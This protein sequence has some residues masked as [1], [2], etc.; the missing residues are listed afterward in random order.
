MCNTC[1]ILCSAFFHGIGHHYCC[2]FMRILYYYDPDIY[3]HTL[4]TLHIIDHG[5]HMCDINVIIIV[6]FL[7]ITNDMYTSIYYL[8]CVRVTVNI[9]YYLHPRDRIYR[10]FI[11][12]LGNDWSSTMKVMVKIFSFIHNANIKISINNYLHCTTSSL[13]Y[14][15]KQIYKALIYYMYIIK[16]LYCAYPDEYRRTILRIVFM[17]AQ[18]CYNLIIICMLYIH[19]YCS[20]TYIITIAFFRNIFKFA[21][22]YGLHHDDKIIF[23]N[24][25]QKNRSICYNTA[26]NEMSDISVIYIQRELFFLSVLNSLHYICFLH[27]IYK[28]HVSYLVIFLKVCRLCH[29]LSYRLYYLRIVVLYI[30]HASKYHYGMSLFHMKYKCQNINL[31]RYSN[32]NPLTTNN[33][34]Y[35]SVC[36]SKCNNNIIHVWPVLNNNIPRLALNNTHHSHN[37]SHSTI[38]TTCTDDSIVGRIY[39][40]DQDYST[41]GNIDPDKY[42]LNSENNIP[43]KNYTEISFN[44]TFESKINTFSI[45]HVNI[46]STPENLS[47]LVYYL[48]GINL[49]F[50][51]FA[52]SESWLKSYNDSLYTIKGYAHECVNREDRPG[53]GVTLYIKKSIN[54]KLRSDLTL[55]VDDVNILFIEIPKN[56][57]NTQTNVLVGVCYRPPHVPA[58]NFIE[59]LDKLLEKIHKEKSIVFFC[60]D[61]NFDTLSLSPAINS[62]A[63]DFHNTFLSYFY[64]PLINNNVTRKNT[65]TGRGSLIDNVFTN[66]LHSSN[67]CQSAILKTD[68]S[69]HYSIIVI[70]DFTLCSSKE[71]KSIIKREFTNKNKSKLNKKLRLQSWDYLFNSENVQLAYTYFHNQIRYMYEECFP[72][73]RIQITYSY[74]LPWMTNNIRTSIKQKHNLY[75]IYVNNPTEENNIKYKTYK[76]KL[77][78]IMRKSERNYFEEQIEHNNH[79]LRKSWKTIKEIIGKNGSYDNTTISYNIN[80]VSTDDPQIFC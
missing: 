80:G 49:Q 7:S 46:R 43:C 44:S 52:I 16:I 5:R 19:V 79:D 75:A 48:Q 50:T 65:I 39:E 28:I 12:I 77:T 78:S 1:V 31:L 27:Y 33:Y 58:S 56:E 47:K 62:R 54:Y 64:K 67:T 66:L 29:I 68:F 3:C 42:F 37:D 74:R 30:F 70:S 38:N 41:L 36:P 17:F 13:S 71:N 25:R 6:S 4:L 21:Q 2:Y 9:N 55:S 23:S 26:H 69:D 22:E 15:L 34:R 10:A 73:S 63:N 76:N 24:N 72:E 60:G 14:T 57:L 8:F 11:L 18:Y 45:Y 61:F 51:I 40:D 32:I 53:G 59:E 35:T 20:S